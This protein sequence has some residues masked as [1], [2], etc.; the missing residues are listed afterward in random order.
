LICYGFYFIRFLLICHALSTHNSSQI[1]TTY[2]TEHDTKNS[3]WCDYEDKSLSYNR[4]LG[5]V[6]CFK[7]IINVFRVLLHGENLIIK[8]GAHLSLTQ[9]FNRFQTNG[10]T[11]I[12]HSIQNQTRFHKSRNYHARLIGN[13]SKKLSRSWIK[14]TN[15]SVAFKWDTT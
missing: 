5:Q 8:D 4:N 11:C 12:L 9:S 3:I 13:C 2:F 15:T 10:H 1:F 7:I 6:G 14:F